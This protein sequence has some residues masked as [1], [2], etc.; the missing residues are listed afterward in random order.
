[1]DIREIENKAKWIRLEVLESIVRGGKGH[2]GGSYSCVELLTSLYYGKFLRISSKDP[3][4]PD[5]DRFIMGKGHA[6]L[7]LYPILLDLGFISR[8]RY[9]EYGKNGSSLGGQ[10]DV[11]IPGVEYNTGSLGHALGIC[12]GMAL[13]AKKDK[14]GFRAVA[15][16]GDAECDEGAIWEAIKFAGEQ[17]LNNL[18]CI[19]DRN[20][21]SVTDVIEGEI[22][23]GG[24]TE[25]LNLF[26]WDCHEING[27]SYPE[28]F[29]TL[30]RAATATRPVMVLANTIKGKG[31]SF[32]EN[33]VKWHHSV[34]TQKEVDMARQEL[35][36]G[37]QR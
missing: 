8:E 13:A 21:L 19:V 7:A 1:M 16:I 20:R 15:L 14:K 17:E 24:F 6:C 37:G 36:L 31:V 33:G 18:I 25:K 35:G 27:H 22:V 29:S 11:S 10:L 5:R 12:A 2:I 3:K 32:M 26:G 34:P 23:F 28:I 9:L 4:S 30:D